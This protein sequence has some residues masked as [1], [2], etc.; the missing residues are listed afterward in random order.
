MNEFNCIKRCTINRLFDIID[1]LIKIWTCNV[2]DRIG[3]RNRVG[4]YLA[5]LVITQ[6]QYL[7]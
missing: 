4:A 2:F 7:G 5:I 3:T 1:S 6:T